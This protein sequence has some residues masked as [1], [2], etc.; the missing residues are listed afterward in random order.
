MKPQDTTQGQIGPA[1]DDLLQ[2]EMLIAQRADE[3]WLHSGGAGG[4]DLMHWMQ[5]E[6]E[7]FESYLG[8]GRPAAALAARA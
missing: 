2:I 3:L 4:T 5:A 8:S 1:E 7:V 6:R